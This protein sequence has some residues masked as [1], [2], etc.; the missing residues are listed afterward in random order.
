MSMLA[1]P[2]PKFFA[3]WLPALAVSA[4]LSAPTAEPFTVAF[5]GMS[6]PIVT[7][8]LGAVGVL[9]ARPLARKSEAT[10]P[11]WQSILVSA[12][13]FIVVELWILQA[14]PGWLFAFVVAIGLGFTGFSMIELLGE[15]LKGLVRSGFAAAKDRVG[16]LLEGSQSKGS[17]NA[18]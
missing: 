4:A 7:C 10:L 15:E 17:D 14:H 3:G 8:I 11:L 2:F 12:I 16:S 6:I 13:M 9:A 18:G 5:E 1:V